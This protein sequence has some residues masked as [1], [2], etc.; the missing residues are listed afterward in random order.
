LLIKLR[1]IGAVRGWKF[2]LVVPAR[3]FAALKKLF[4]SKGWARAHVKN[5]P[6]LFYLAQKRLCEFFSLLAAAVRAL[7]GS[8]LYYL[9]LF[10]CF[11][12]QAAA[13]ERINKWEALNS[14][15]ETQAGHNYSAS[16]L[17]ESKKMAFVS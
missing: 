1:R 11:N 4:C 9:F 10:L 7:S 8:W 13:A 14:L 6:K 5:N 12:M 15:L 3:P 17:P 16:F 2:L